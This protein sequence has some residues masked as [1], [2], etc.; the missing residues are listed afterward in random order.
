MSS[1]SDEKKKTVKQ[2]YM[3]LLEITASINVCRKEFILRLNRVVAYTI[4]YLVFTI[5]F[6]ISGIAH[7]VLFFII[8]LL[9]SIILSLLI[10]VLLA[11]Q[12]KRYQE[13]IENGD[14]CFA[15]LS[16]M[17]DWELYRNSLLYNDINTRYQKVIYNYYTETRGDKS[18]KNRKYT[19]IL[20][21]LN[22][23]IFV[24]FVISVY[25]FLRGLHNTI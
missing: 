14:D 22:I 6:L 25:L 12:L 7:T 15:Q 20:H 16:N 17:L 13:L 5:Y 21:L 23:T 19:L 8:S 11:S 24:I 2:L 3:K 10:R 9:F 4:L 1:Q 18:L